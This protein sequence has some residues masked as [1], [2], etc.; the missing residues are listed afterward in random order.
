MYQKHKISG[1]S[2]LTTGRITAAH[3]RSN[4]IEGTLAP[5]S[6]HDWTC[7]SYGPPTGILP[8]ITCKSGIIRKVFWYFVARWEWDTV[9]TDEQGTHGGAEW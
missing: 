8:I 9:I 1:Q 7:A 5:S 3:G 6:E 4:G 2:N